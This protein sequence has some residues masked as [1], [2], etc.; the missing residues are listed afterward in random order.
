MFS[1]NKPILLQAF[2]CEDLS[3]YERDCNNRIQFEA[4]DTVVTS[5]ITIVEMSGLRDSDEEVTVYNA[6]MKLEEYGT[7]IFISNPILIKPGFIYEVQ[8]KQSPPKYCCTGHSLNSEM[9]LESDIMI[10]FHDDP[11]VGGDKR[12]LIVGMDIIPL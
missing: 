6:K 8:M 5:E 1:T 4:L 11:E 3:H 9:K 12:G 2:Y 10:T 7:S